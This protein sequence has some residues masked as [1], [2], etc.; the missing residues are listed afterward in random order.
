[1]RVEIESL[2]T[3]WHQIYIGLKIEE[4]DLL[5]QRLS[6]LKKDK[7][8]HFHIMSNYDGEPSVGDIEFYLQENEEDN[9]ILSGGAISPNE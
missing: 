9:M 2:D 1:M 7:G 4:V 6:L 8:Q 3:G 5:I